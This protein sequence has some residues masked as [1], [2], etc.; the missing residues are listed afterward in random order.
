MCNAAVDFKEVPLNGILGGK[1][2]FLFKSSNSDNRQP[3]T[4]YTHTHKAC[5]TWL[6]GVS[7][8]LYL[9]G[10]GPGI[11]QR[12]GQPT[13]SRTAN[14]SHVGQ[15]N[16]VGV[17]TPLRQRTAYNN[18]FHDGAQCAAMYAGC[19]AV[20]VSTHIAFSSFKPPSFWTAPRAANGTTAAVP[21]AL[22]TL[23]R[24]QQW[25]LWSTHYE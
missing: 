6:R 25:L 10:K 12:Y 8:P 1:S 14:S 11:G 3:H 17:F 24:C 9:N 21:S 18:S 13:M 2:L 23:P 16:T 7:Q 19:M 15:Y 22:G 20:R 4:Q 5:K